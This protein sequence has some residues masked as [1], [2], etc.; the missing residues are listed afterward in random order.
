VPI[1]KIFRT[2]FGPVL[3]VYQGVRSIAETD[4]HSWQVAV[5]TLQGSLT[6]THQAIPCAAEREP[7]VF[8]AESIARLVSRKAGSY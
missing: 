3:F 2:T 4:C 7:G 6:V 1:A 5:W 8:D